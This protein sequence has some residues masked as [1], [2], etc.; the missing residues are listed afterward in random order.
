MGKSSLVR[1]NLRILLLLVAVAAGVSAVVAHYFVRP[2]PITKIT[3]RSEWISAIKHDRC[4]V[5]VDGDWNID[6]VAFRK[7]FSKFAVWCE[8]RTD[9][10]ALT[11][12][13]DP[14]D[15]TNDVWNICDELWHT[16]N[17]KR[18]GLKNY[19]GAGRVLW[20]DKG[21]IVDYAWCMELMDD[22]DIDNISALKT[23]TRNA[24]H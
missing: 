2:D 20:I 3:S 5:F 22:G 19:G 15:K 4:V 9:T 10:H 1:F 16:H 13:I 11:L 12:K 18:G 8:S 6:M 24:F 17:I 23:R 21:Q 7:P 14:A